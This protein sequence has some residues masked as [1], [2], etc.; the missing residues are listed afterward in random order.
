[1]IKE[2][3][4]GGGGRDS[5][6]AAKKERQ[7]WTAWYMEINGFPEEISC[8]EQGKKIYQAFCPF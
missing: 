4:L 1:M 8:H 6:N 2:Y 7:Q 5:M 3:M